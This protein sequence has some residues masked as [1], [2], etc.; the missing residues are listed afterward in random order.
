VGV[1]EAWYHEALRK[2]NAFST[3][4]ETVYLLGGTNGQYT[5]PTN[6]ES[7][8]QRKRRIHGVN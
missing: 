6:G 2:I 4:T 7:L 3:W 8:G 5:V 1:D